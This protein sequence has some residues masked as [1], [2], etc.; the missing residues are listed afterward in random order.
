MTA[1]SAEQVRH[2]LRDDGRIERASIAAGTVG[3]L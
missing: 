2:W 3:A 1:L